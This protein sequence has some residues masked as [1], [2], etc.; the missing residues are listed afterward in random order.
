MWQC[1]PNQ[2]EGVTTIKVWGT[3]ILI[4]HFWYFQYFYCSF[5]GPK[6]I[7][8]LYLYPT[9]LR[10]DCF[11]NVS[12]LNGGAKSLR[13]PRPIKKT[14]TAALKNATAADGRV[15]SHFSGVYNHLFL[16]IL[17]SLTD[18]GKSSTK[19]SFCPEQEATSPYAATGR[20]CQQPSPAARS[21]P[22]PRTSSAGCWAV[23]WTARAPSLWRALCRCCSW[24]CP[25][26]WC[27]FW[28]WGKEDGIYA[29]GQPS[30]LPWSL[31]T[32]DGKVFNACTVMCKPNP[33]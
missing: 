26:G 29:E 14:K 31:E 16:G 20:A 6:H 17:Q 15:C 33:P 4:K 18:R 7:G 30:P 23:R 8:H 25:T 12:I 22:A 10:D 3:R 19:S 21:T 27:W 5:P 28:G 32:W 2:T 24:G 13:H 9:P 11:Q 1:I